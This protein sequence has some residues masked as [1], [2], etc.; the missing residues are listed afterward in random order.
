MRRYGEAL[1]GRALGAALALG[2]GLGAHGAG[3]ATTRL[4]IAGESSR[5]GI[6]DPSVEYAPFC[7]MGWLSYSAVFG[8]A[9]PFGPHV[10]TR[11]AYTLDQ[12]RSWSFSGVA[13]PST[14]AILSLPD[15]S[16]LP[17]V[18]NSEVSSLVH[19]PGDPGHEW[20]LFAHRIFRGLEDPF[21]EEQN[22][23]AY[24]WIV[25][26]SAP[27]PSGP[28]SEEVALLS[29]GPF[30]PAPYDRVRV[31]INEL[32]PTLAS[33]LV[34]S[35]PGSFEREGVLYLSLT[36]LL[37]SGPD[38]IVLLASDDHGESWRYVATPISSAD[39]PALGFL[40]FDGSAIVEEAGRTMLLVTPESP[41]VLHDGTLVLEFEDLTQ[42]RL[43]RVGGVPLVLRHFAPRPGQ[44]A[45]RR[46]GQADYHER[47]RGGGL[48]MPSLQAADLPEMFQIDETH[49]SLALPREVPALGSP[50]GLAGLCTALAGCAAWYASRHRETTARGRAPCRREAVSAG[51]FDSR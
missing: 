33:L 49:E 11:I 32:D 26:R 16:T 27:D 38:R 28:W 20:K 2:I 4:Q 10:E 40:S 15:G 29:S 14:P 3:S 31:A 17:G 5:N 42:G 1:L 30:P 21:T 22:L 19:D 43:R 47:N 24:S 44:P 50:T 8:G 45:D 9:S 34:Y 23:P 41:G 37:A 18:W 35:E 36:G 7:S 12:G 25:L 13:I 48:L 39:A 6:F 46:G 51:A